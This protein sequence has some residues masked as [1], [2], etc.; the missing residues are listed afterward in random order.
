M[1][2]RSLLFIFSIVLATHGWAQTNEQDS[3]V[4][5]RTLIPS[6][7]IDY[8][9]ILTIPSEI[10]TKY[11]GGLELLF[12]EKFP[13]IVELGQATLSPEGAY[14]NGV[15]ESEGFYYRIGAGYYSQFKP[16]NKIGI[17]FRYA[18]SNFSESGRIFIDSPSGVQENFVQTIDRR[19]LTA[20]WFEMVVY[21]DQKLADLFS[22]GINIRLRVLQNYDEQT[23][24]DVYAIPGY[25]RSFEN[26]VPAANLFFKVSF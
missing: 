22:I 8:G 26:T 13:L 4:S 7:L 1:V 16:T 11:E 2:R 12:F 21:S 5:V 15:Y 17:S 6:I 19:D 18:V 24:L 14:S 9:K 3:V 23:P 10:E 20:N 25:G